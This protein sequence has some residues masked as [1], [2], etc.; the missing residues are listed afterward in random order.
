MGKKLSTHY[1]EKGKGKC[2]IH[3]DMKQEMFYIKYYDNN[4]RRF[5]TEDFES[6]TLRYVEDAAENWTLGIKKLEGYE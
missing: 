5:F 6:K 4:D 1:S 2:E 3:V